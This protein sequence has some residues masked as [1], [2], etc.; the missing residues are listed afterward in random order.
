MRTDDAP[1]DEQLVDLRGND[2]WAQE[3]K[4]NTPVFE[5]VV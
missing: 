1:S 5:G 4:C 3:E 2:L